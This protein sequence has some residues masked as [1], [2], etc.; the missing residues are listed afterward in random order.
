MGDAISIKPASAASASLPG[1]KGS[2]DRGGVAW[3]LFEGGRTPFLILITIYIFMPYVAST[4]I[5][6]P[7]RGQEVISFWQQVVGLMAGLTAALWWGK[8]DGSGLSIVTI[9]MCASAAQIMFNYSEILHNSLLVRAAGVRG[10]HKAS[11]LALSFGNLFAVLALAFTAWAFAL[12]GT[13]DW[14]W[15]PA[16]PLLGLDTAMHEH[17]RVVALLSALLLL[18][19]SIPFFLF[20]PDAEPTGVRL[21]QAL[22]EGALELFGMIRTIGHFKNAAIFMGARMLFV[23]GMNGVLI[24]GGLFAVGVMRWTALEMLTYGI[25]LSSVSVLGGFIARWMDAAFGPNHSLRISIFV[26]MIGLAAMI[27]MKPDQIFYFWSYDISTQPRLWNGPVFQTLPDLCFLLVNFFNATF[28]TCQYA[29]SRTLLTRLTP[30]E[31]SG[32]FFGVYALSG[33]ATAWLAPMLVNFGTRTTGTQQGGFVMLLLLLAA[34]LIC[35]MCV[36]GGGRDLA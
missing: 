30:P 25:L 18:L 23:D 21:A 1:M 8:P 3:A 4:L 17:E 29:S 9:M 31:Q 22:R 34:G 14:S 35:L 12:P 32:T 33:V 5:G 2:L 26:S 10:A 19:G 13:V 28:I 7:V 24:Y 20:T 11:G 6:D 16:A 36:R 15:V 27:G